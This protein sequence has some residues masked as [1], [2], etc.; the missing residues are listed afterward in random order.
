[1]DGLASLVNSAIGSIPEPS[2]SMP[3][4]SPGS[5]GI[6][7]DPDVHE[8]TIGGDGNPHPTYNVDGTLRRKRGRRRGVN[9]DDAPQGQG[10]AVEFDEDGNP[11]LSREEI[12]RHATTGVNWFINGARQLFGAEWEASDDEKRALHDAFAA[13]VEAGGVM[14]M[15]PWLALLN[16]LALY[17]VTH[18]GPQ[19]RARIVFFIQLLRSMRKG[20]REDTVEPNRIRPEGTM[21]GGSLD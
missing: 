16:Q 5:G 2:D 15:P 11:K 17:A 1:M 18:T 21:A 20:K 12:E 3:P 9:Y 7:F 6:P 4:A 10:P 8:H 19:T 14:R 13:Y